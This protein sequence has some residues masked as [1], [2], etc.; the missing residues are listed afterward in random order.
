MNWGFLAAAILF[1]VAG[2][3]LMKKFALDHSIKGILSYA[4]PIFVIGGV[5]FG[6]NLVLYARAVQSIPLVVAYPVLVG[7]SILLV[8]LAATLLFSEK[9]TPSMMG[10]MALISVG[11]VLLTKG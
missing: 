4:N 5:M 11:L 6:I 3:L 8:A 1:N 2:N 9:L 7:A 10:G